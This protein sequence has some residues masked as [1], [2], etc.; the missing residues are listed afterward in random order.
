VV[1]MIMKDTHTVRH[2]PQ[3]LWDWVRIAR[4]VAEEW[5]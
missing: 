4:E 5:A 2:Q 1:E 3:R